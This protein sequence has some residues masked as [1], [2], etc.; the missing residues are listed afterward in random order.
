MDGNKLVENGYWRSIHWKCI[1]IN[2]K[3]FHQLNKQQNAETNS[4][5]MKP[6]ITHIPKTKYV[7]QN[8]NV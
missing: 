3:L 7:K 6:H 8:K 5:Q 1:M 2:S 4:T